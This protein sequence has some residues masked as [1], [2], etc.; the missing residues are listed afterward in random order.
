MKAEADARASLSPL[1]RGSTSGRCRACLLEQR[2][3]TLLPSLIMVNNERE[4]YGRTTM[5]QRGKVQRSD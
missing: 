5:I 3:S 1:D 2:G 4:A